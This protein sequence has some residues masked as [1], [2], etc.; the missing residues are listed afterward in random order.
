MKTSIAL[1]MLGFVLLAA[2]RPPPRP[3]ATYTIEPF[4]AE[5]VPGKLDARWFVRDV[6]D[7]HGAVT[8]VELVY[9]PI[10]PSD[11]T[12][13]RTGVVWERG[14]SVLVNR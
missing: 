11:P 12:V 10:V 5:S 7:E 4:H 14:R 8:G 9:C 6:I 2:C 1:S 13:C 3:P